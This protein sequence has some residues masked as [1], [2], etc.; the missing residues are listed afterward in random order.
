MTQLH[1]RSRAAGVLVAL[2]L[3]SP[4]ALAAAADA[5]PGDR[6]PQSTVEPVIDA[7]FADPDLLLVD[8]V[9]HA[10][11]TN[12][13]G[14]NIQHQTST[15]LVNWTPQPD[16]LPVLGAWV[17]ECSFSPGGETDHC[18]WAP[19]VS[20]VEDGYAM[21]YTAHDEASGRQCIGAAFS[22]TPDGPFVPDDEPLVCPVELGGAIDAS[23]YAENGQLYLLWKADGNCCSLP[24]ILYIQPLSADGTTL[25]GPPVELLRNDAGDS[26]R[27][28]V[29]APTLIK[30]D[31]TYYLIHS[32]NDFY[33]GNYRTQYA[34][35]SSLF[36]PYVDQGE[37][38]TSEM[39]QGQ[40]VGP[41]G[42]DVVV[43]PDG[44]LYIVFHGWDE[45]FTYRAMYVSRLGFDADGALNAALAADLYEAED[46][47][48]R[49]AGVRRDF[50]AS[51]GEVVGGL[52]FTDSSITIRVYAEKS[53]PAILGIRYANGSTDGGQGVDATSGLTV[54]GAPAGTVTLGYTTWGNWQVEE[55]PIQLKKGWNEV[56]LTKQTYYAEVD[57]FYLYYGHVDREPAGPPASPADA[58]RYEAEDGLVVHA[59]D[60]LFDP[61]AS[62][63]HKVG[64]LDFP[65][66]SITWN[67]CVEQAG[68]ATIAIRYANGSERG[69]YSLEAVHSVTV[70][71][72]DAGL[73]VY[74]HTRWGNWQTIEHDVVLEKGCNT[75][76]LTRVAWYAE[77]DFIEIY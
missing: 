67:V 49:N 73:V 1:T 29:E 46:G 55:V 54:N 19:E 5:A 21:Y 68:P 11:A 74:P 75:I 18:V 48:I 61:S 10:Y 71:G 30:H 72:R 56:T 44:E 16:A 3:L 26:E 2:A 36:G 59:R 13:D 8:G 42:Q 25:T 35:S 45:T 60:D 22:A 76:T 38:L 51:G 23:T 39:F 58:V 64:G 50:T 9:Y 4:L 52:D 62:N 24:S 6:S 40:V 47:V 28:V 20:A 37:L 15:D 77:I 7:N 31:G 33:G 43:G 53:G 12:S 27:F 65:D 17:G 63:Q 70:N 57:A 34:T 66:S 41:G 69:G 14:D 32:A